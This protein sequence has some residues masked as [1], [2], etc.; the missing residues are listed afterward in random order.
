M[1]GVEYISSQDGLK[2]LELAGCAQE[3]DTFMRVGGAFHARY[4]KN[5]RMLLFRQAGRSFAATIPI[6]NAAR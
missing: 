5:C 1:C 2:K 3:A 4:G 6:I